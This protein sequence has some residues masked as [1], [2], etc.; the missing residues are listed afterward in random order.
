MFDYAV[1]YEGRIIDY[2]KADTDRKALNLARKL[3][4]SPEKISV[5]RV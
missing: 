4:S 5:T 1:W 3:F 2:V